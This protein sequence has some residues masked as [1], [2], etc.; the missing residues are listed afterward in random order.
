MVAIKTIFAYNFCISDSISIKFWHWVLKDVF[1]LDFAN[2]II[3]TQHC[4]QYG[5]QEKSVWLIL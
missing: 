2:F 3:L 4:I 5:G 1:S